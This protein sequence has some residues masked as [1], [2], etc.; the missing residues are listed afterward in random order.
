ME[1]SAILSVLASEIEQGRLI[2]PTS[3][4]TA[5]KIKKTLEDPDCSL[6]AVIRLVQA[7]PLLSTKIVAIANSIVFNRSGKRITDVRSA[8]TLIGMRTVRNIATAVVVQQLAGSQAKNELV[9]QLWQHSAHVAALAQVIARRI[10]HQDPDTAMFA[11]IIH[12]ITWFYLLAREKHYPGLVDENAASS[13]NSDED[14]EDETEVECE[15]KIGTAIL[16]ALSVPEPIIEGIVYLWQGYLAFPPTS[17]GDT[18]LCADQLSPIKSPFAL[19]SQQAGHHISSN[20]DLLADQETLSDILK[21]SEEEVK[22]L[23]QALCS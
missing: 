5:M 15:V 18:L 16:K 23:T 19:P 9:T 14:L 2:F 21:N 3:T 11:G 6:D 13:W 7:E 10:T 22:S 8:V 17:L 12:E 20:I 4:N 1:K